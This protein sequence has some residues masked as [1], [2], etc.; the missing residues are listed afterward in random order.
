[1]KRVRGFKSALTLSG[2]MLIATPVCSSAADKAQPQNTP[3]PT[4]APTPPPKSK[5]D[6]NAWQ[7][8]HRDQF[9]NKMT[10]NELNL[11][12]TRKVDETTK[13]YGGFQYSESSNGQS[14]TKIGGGVTKEF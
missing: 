12:A 6:L 9:G 4:P 7:T 3:A 10:T 11:G 13:I 2:L 8:V 14:S 1:M 5:I